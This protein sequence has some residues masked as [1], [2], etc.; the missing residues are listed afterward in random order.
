MGRSEEPF[1]LVTQDKRVCRHVVVQAALTSDFSVTLGKP[2]YP[3]QTLRQSDE[4]IEL[5]GP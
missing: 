4:G 3:S 2:Y 1:C 5:D